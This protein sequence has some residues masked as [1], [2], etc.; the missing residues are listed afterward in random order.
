MARD[1]AAPAPPRLGAPARPGRDRPADRAASRSAFRAARAG[2]AGASP[3]GAARTAVTSS[4]AKPTELCSESGIVRSAAKPIVTGKAERRIVHPARRAASSAAGPGRAAGREGLAEPADRQQR[5]VDPE[6]QADH[7]R[8]RLDQDRD[9]EEAGEKRGHA[10]GE[11]DREQPDADREHR[12][13]RSPKASSSR[14]SVRGRTRSSAER[15]SAAL[16]MRRSKFSGTSP[17]QPSQ[18]SDRSAQPRGQRARRRAQARE[19]L[20]DRAASRVEPDDDQESALRALKDRVARVERGQRSRDPG[21]L[22][23][24]RTIVSRAS[25]PSGVVG[26]GHAFDDEENAVGE[27][28][29]EAPGELVVHGLRL[30][31]RHPRG[32]LEAILDVPGARHDERGGR[33]PQEDDGPA[34][35]ARRLRTSRSSAVVR[36]Q[37]SRRIPSARG[38]IGWGSWHG[39]APCEKKFRRASCF[40]RRR[41]QR[42]GTCSSFS[43]SYPQPVIFPTRRSYSASEIVGVRAMIQT[44]SRL[45]RATMASL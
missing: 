34:D 45:V 20:L 38:V 15:A 41:H 23:T 7:R 14:S 22:W 28:R 39:A 32:D 9:R 19:Q 27:R 11:R 16:A 8:D 42:W 31:G 21:T 36:D 33:R 25:R 30:F 24:S 18:T 17:V 40:R 12:G 1:A 29:L 2:R 26:T 10:E 37:G 13:E 43:V 44:K 5:V 35:T 3:R 4:P 6:A